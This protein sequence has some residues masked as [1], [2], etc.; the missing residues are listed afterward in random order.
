LLSGLVSLTAGVIFV[1][2]FVLMAI[3]STLEADKCP[4]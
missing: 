1:L 3:V 2:V 4:A